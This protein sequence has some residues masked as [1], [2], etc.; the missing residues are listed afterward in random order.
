[1]SPT[2]LHEFKSADRLNLQTPIM[3]LYLQEQ[4][5][6]SHSQADSSSHKFMLKG[7]QTGGM[8]R[9]HGWVF[10]A[11]SRDTM[12]AWYSDVKSLTEKTGL[13][14]DAFVRR[15]ARSMSAGSLGARSVSSDGGMEEDEADHT[16]FSPVASQVEHP[17][18]SQVPERPQPG[19]R[20]PSDVNVERSLQVPLSPSSGTSSGDRDALA[21]A[22]SLPGSG[23]PF[24]DPG[25]VVTHEG[26]YAPNDFHDGPAEAT[27]GQDNQSL[28]RESLS[29]NEVVPQATARHDDLVPPV[30]STAAPT[31]YTSQSSNVRQTSTAE[32]K[33]SDLP[34]QSKSQLGP[35]DD[36]FYQPTVVGNERQA[37]LAS[38]PIVHEANTVPVELSTNTSLPVPHGAKIGEHTNGGI[39]R[40][41]ASEAASVMTT[42][43]DSTVG[44]PSE[45]PALVSNDSQQTISHLHIP[46]EYPRSTRSTG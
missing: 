44:E 41:P 37:S 35:T 15:H 4:K 9:G 39:E 26:Y 11:E 8:H 12:L 13:E 43:T 1:M 29:R 20:F 46:G 5:L 27:G 2:H 34:L 16:P 19:G 32:P 10:R 42:L 33:R 14:R 22:G 3:S 7:R 30:T 45:K 31:S 38:H 25:Q 36:P 24:G 40:A 28:R 21:A 18:Q 17:L 6:G 23:V